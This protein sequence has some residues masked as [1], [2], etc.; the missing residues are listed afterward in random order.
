MPVI[1]K[2]KGVFRTKIPKAF[3][4]AEPASD[5]YSNDDEEEQR[6]QVETDSLVL[7]MGVTGAGKSYFI[8][9]LKP[10]SV[11]EGHGLG[12]RECSCASAWERSL[13][14]FPP[15]RTKKCKLV[16]LEIGTCTVAVVDTPGFDD[17]DD[18]DA[19]VLAKISRFLT[20][21]RR[22]DIKLK[23]VLFL[24]D[25]NTVRFS[26]SHKRYLDTFRKICGEEAYKNVA[27]VTT[28]WG[29]EDHGVKLKREA[30]LQ[31]GP[32]KDFKAKGADVFQ[33]NGSPGMART[34]VGHMLR[35]DNVVLKMQTELSSAHDMLDH[36]T[37]G[38][39]LAFQLDERLERSERQIRS[40]ISQIKDAQACQ[41]AS[42]VRQLQK[43][44]KKEREKHVKQRDSR[45]A[46]R[47]KIVQE[48]DEKIVEVKKDQ[49]SK[50][51]KWKSRLRIF[52]M[53][54]GPL[55]S[56]GTAFI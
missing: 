42:K 34:I 35:K 20:A 36:T 7:V 2:L 22:L 17:D 44:L 55:I 3:D 27:L 18:S 4:K 29:G 40:L 52:A 24:H 56:I 45:G 46:L 33:Y 43:E 15:Q 54:L 28:M 25:I 12:S 41:D 48:T 19:E 14:L 31:T 11:V 5:D 9:Q 53:V 1:Q 39:A 32:W 13:T 51:D 21:Q 26:G 37:A 8:N 38:A 16:E 23:G 50:G 49:K 47:P 6:D 10:A 30:E